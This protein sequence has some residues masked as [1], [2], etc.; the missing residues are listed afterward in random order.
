M[1]TKYEGLT[2]EEIKAACMKEFNRTLAAILYRRWLERQATED[3]AEH[4]A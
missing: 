3:A 2:R 1:T 4:G